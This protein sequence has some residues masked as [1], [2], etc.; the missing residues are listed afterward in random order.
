[1]LTSSTS[2]AYSLLFKLLCD[3]GDDVLVPQPSYP[4]FDLLTHLEACARRRIGST[5]AGAWCIDRDEPRARAHPATRAIL[6]VSPN[7]P[8]GSMLRADDREW[9]VGL[10]RERQLALISDEVFADYPLAPRPDATSLARRGARADVHP[11]RAVEVRRA[12]AD[13]AG[14]DRRRAGR[15]A[16]WPTRSSGSS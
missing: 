9:L 3:P 10:A 6:V 8:T 4:L 11:R 2:E 13:E 14:V 15:P 12:A 16:S 7:N 1:M 5:P